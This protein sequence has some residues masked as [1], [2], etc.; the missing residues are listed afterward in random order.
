MK[1]AVF[2]V[3]F[4]KMKHYSVDQMVAVFSN[5]GKNKSILQ[6]SQLSLVNQKDVCLM[7]PAARRLSYFVDTVTGFTEK[8]SHLQKSNVGYSCG[9]VVDSHTYI[10]KSFNNS[11]FFFFE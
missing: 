6:F 3:S 2:S 5:Q 4:Q 8:Y 11:V 1:N 9:Q 10:R 7:W